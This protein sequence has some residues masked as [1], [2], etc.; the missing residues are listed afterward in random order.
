MG[1]CQSTVNGKVFLSLL[2]QLNNYS[3]CDRSSCAQSVHD[4]DLLKDKESCC[5]SERSQVFSFCLLI[6]CSRKT[7]PKI[8]DLWT[9]RLVPVT[10]QS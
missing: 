7:K 6:V 4:R 1:L 8:L 10:K 9:V 3:E 2:A 5:A